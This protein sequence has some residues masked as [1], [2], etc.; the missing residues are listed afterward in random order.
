MSKNNNTQNQKPN[1]IFI[2]APPP[3]PQPQQ[4]NGI[5]GGLG[6]IILSAVAG[7]VLS[8]FGVPRLPGIKF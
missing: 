1:P 8:Q 4:D 5:F 3:Q 7:A 2:M 6:G